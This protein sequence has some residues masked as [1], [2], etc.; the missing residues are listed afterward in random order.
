MMDSIK[1]AEEFWKQQ[2]FQKAHDIAWSAIGYFEEKY[3]RRMTRSKNLPNYI[4]DLLKSRVRA[5]E[6]DGLAGCAL[7]YGNMESESIYFE[8]ASGIRFTEFHGYDL[9]SS[10]VTSYQ[11]RDPEGVFHSHVEDVNDLV[12]A[13][14]E[15]FHLII[16]NHG[17]HHVVN[18]GN[19]FFQAKRA[20][21][22]AGLF[23]MYE[24]IRSAVLANPVAQPDRL[25]LLVVPPFP[26]KV[27]HKPRGEAPRL[28][29][30][31]PARLFRP[32]RSPQLNGDL[33]GVH[34]LLSPD[35][36]CLFRRACLSHL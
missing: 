33:G 18:V 8:H 9:T 2:N 4:W 34:V 29:G 7:V 17:I 23:F 1:S 31:V 6:R 25:R 5:V 3:R 36:F 28:V 30:A 27:L 16:S 32:E 11:P 21:A 13:K 35:T 20:L 26:P 24:W 10:L 12:L 22:P 15:F 14:E 19:V